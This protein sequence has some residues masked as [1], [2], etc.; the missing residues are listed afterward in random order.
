MD[1]SP[2]PRRFLSSFV[3]FWCRDALFAASGAFMSAS[4]LQTLYLRL[5]ISAQTVSFLSAFSQAVNVTFSLLFANITKRYAGTRRATTLL[6]FSHAV[7][8]AMYLV[9]CLAGDLPVSAAVAAAFLLTSAADIIIAV[10]AIFSYKLVC[11]VIHAG[12]YSMYASVC[13]IVNGVFTISIGLFLPFMFARFDFMRVTALAILL[14]AVLMAVS[15]LLTSRLPLLPG[16]ELPPEAPGRME[17][18]NREVLR[19]DSFRKM[20]LPNFMRG[21]GHGIL[22]VIPLLAIRYGGLTEDNASII[23]SLTNIALFAG[24][25]A[26]AFLRRR[27]VRAS[28]LALTGSLL[29]LLLAPALSGSAPRFI[30]LY[31]LAHLGYQFISLAIPDIVYNTVGQENIAAFN[32]WRMSLTYLGSVL[33]TALIG[34]L[35]ER[36]DGRLIGIVSA[37]AMV[38]AS[39]AYFLYFRKRHI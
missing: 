8:I 13:G 29:F 39:A 28:A 3:L 25:A 20:A 33:S 16:S 15:G 35:I 12:D 18:I 32:T 7:I 26:Y 38:Y 34:I 37:A 10:R 11:E 5:G 4:I 9:L 31:T 36:V 30:V 6:C 27:S 17:L 22:A 14:G 24:S 19:D 1:T 23:V 2:A 21:I